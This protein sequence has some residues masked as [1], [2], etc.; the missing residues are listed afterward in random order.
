MVAIYEP[1]K[2]PNGGYPTYNPNPT[3]NE[4]PDEVIS[5]TADQYLGFR[6]DFANGRLTEAQSGNW[7]KN[8]FEGVGD[9][10][11]TGNA[12]SLDYSIN[13]TGKNGAYIVKGKIND[14]S[15][16]IKA[17]VDGDKII[18][19]ASLKNVDEEKGGVIKATGGHE[20]IEPN[21]GDWLGDVINVKPKGE[22]KTDS[23]SKTAYNYTIN[24]GGT[25]LEPLEDKK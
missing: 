23:S 25:T 11:K 17:K 1:N 22:G 12:N 6:V 8:M 3:F 7:D 13:V 15:F 9:A 18:F 10:I 21:L 4:N 16:E 2:Q 14:S 19:N 5:N 20:E 24:N